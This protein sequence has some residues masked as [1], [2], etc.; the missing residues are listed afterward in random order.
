MSLFLNYIQH[1]FRFD[2]SKKHNHEMEFLHDD[3]IFNII[4]HVNTL[5][6]YYLYQVST[7]FRKVVQSYYKNKCNANKVIRSDMDLDLLGML[8]GNEQTISMF[9]REGSY[10]RPSYH[11]F[12]II[13]YFN[14][15]KLLINFDYVYS[16]YQLECIINNSCKQGLLNVIIHIGK[17]NG[18]NDNFVF[19]KAFLYDRPDIINYVEEK[20]KTSKMIRIGDSGKI[21]T[22]LD[23]TKAVY[24]AANAGNYDLVNTYL[25]KCHHSKEFVNLVVILILRDKLTMLETILTQ[26]K[27][28]TKEYKTL[29]RAANRI[30]RDDIV[31][32]IERF[33]KS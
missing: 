3:A 16:N 21:T 4:L 17:T 20:Y 6:Y 25:S 28:S 31:K 11:I 9:S 18:L 8:I 30:H 15:P 24:T 23:Y 14:K 13:S 26:T 1:I 22:G 33:S 10:I 27:L 29:I 19:Q 12:T 5:H 2:Q 32:I 7:Q